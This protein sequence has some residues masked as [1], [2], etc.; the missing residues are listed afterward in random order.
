MNATEGIEWRERLGLDVEG[1]GCLM[2]STGSNSRHH[3][4]CLLHPHAAATVCHEV[5]G[6]LSSFLCT[7]HYSNVHLVLYRWRDV[8]FRAN[9][10]ECDGNRYVLDDDE[11]HMTFVNEI[12]FLP[13]LNF[14]HG[15]KCYRH[16][17][18]ASSD[19]CEET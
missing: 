7:L 18:H 12:L 15:M 16:G 6:S 11:W 13:R 9:T 10:H 1:S 19:A 8:V 2:Q 4:R 17:K 5:P 3:P 14:A